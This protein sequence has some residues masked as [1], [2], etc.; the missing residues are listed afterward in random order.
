MLGRKADGVAQSGEQ[1]DAGASGTAAIAEVLESVQKVARAQARQGV[2]L[3][4]IEGKLEAGFSD[5]RTSLQRGGPRAGASAPLVWDELLDAA[6]ALDAAAAH[7]AQTG[8]DELARGLRAIVT[9][10]E[11]FMAQRNVTRLSP[12]GEPP[13]PALVRVVGTVTLD[14]SRAPVA[15]GRVVR[16]VRAAALENG[17][18]LR[19]GEVLVARA[20]PQEGETQ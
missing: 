3:E 6:D 9:R 10:L 12:L 4:G 8:A 14:G 18:L 20:T 17:A 2:R 5:L 13:A 15:E 1:T 16:V 19:E 11:R 7:S